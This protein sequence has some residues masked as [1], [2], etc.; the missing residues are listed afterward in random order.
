MKKKK[1]IKILVLN[2]KDKKQSLHCHHGTQQ[3][4]MLSANT[5]QVPFLVSPSRTEDT[6]RTTMPMHFSSLLISIPSSAKLPGS[7][8]KIFSSQIFKDY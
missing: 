1:T 6:A 7:L 3:K 8:K 2:K 5:G 4:W